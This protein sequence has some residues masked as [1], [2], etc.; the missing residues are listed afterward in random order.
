MYGT[1]YIGHA[2]AC[3][4][5]F[6]TFSIWT[7][8]IGVSGWLYNVMLYVV[9]SAQLQ[10][11]VCVRT[12]DFMLVMAKLTPD[13]PKKKWLAYNCWSEEALTLKLARPF[14]GCLSRSK[15]GMT[16]KFWSDQVLLVIVP[17]SNLPVLTQRV[18]GG[19]RLPPAV[20]SC[21]LCCPCSF[22]LPLPVTV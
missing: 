5:T 3:T 12:V 11:L 13:L 19:H 6:S 10:D 15:D 20:V 18:L 4:L 14:R 16:Q 2:N 17:S 8:R 9:S 21:C 22:F 1:P 7:S